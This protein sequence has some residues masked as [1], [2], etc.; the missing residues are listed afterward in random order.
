LKK[1]GETKTSVP[2]IRLDC[3]ETSVAASGCMGVAALGRRRTSRQGPVSDGRVK[4][5]HH[6]QG[7]HLEAST[8]PVLRLSAFGF[9]LIASAV[10]LTPWIIVFVLTDG[11]SQG[12]VCICMW[13]IIWSAKLASGLAHEQHISSFSFTGQG[14]PE[15]SMA[16]TWLR[17]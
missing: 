3:T 6:R 13:A 16:I 2:E 7:L 5:G 14:G 12:Q 17:R 11:R 8:A 9:Q 15:P 10:S 1:K 4:E